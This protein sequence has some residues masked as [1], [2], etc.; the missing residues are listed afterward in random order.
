MAPESRDLNVEDAC[1]RFS[2]IYTGAIADVL[3]EMGYSKQCLPAAIQSLNWDQRVAGAAMTVEGQQT[4]SK[5]PEE[6]YIPVLQMLGDLQPG[7]VIVSC[8][9][10][11]TASALISAS[12]R[13]RR[14]NFGVPGE[15]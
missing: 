11:T 13:A 4:S 15:L 2:L 10:Q 14:P 5:D 1:R 8:H 9:N 12:Y 6:I 3:D 7:D